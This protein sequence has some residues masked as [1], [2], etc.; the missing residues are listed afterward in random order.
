MPR[1]EY[2][3][4]PARELL[5]RILDLGKLPEFSSEQVT[6]ND[7]YLF[8]RDKVF[9]IA[10]MVLDRI[11]QTPAEFGSI[12]A[13]TSLNGQLQPVIA[14]L[15]Q[16]TGN[17]NGIHLLNAASYME[18]GVLQNLWGLPPNAANTVDTDGISILLEKQAGFSTEA[19]RQLGVRR[20]ELTNA[21]TAQSQRVEA[22]AVQIEASRELLARDRAESAA[23]VAN[24]Q[25]QYEL[26]E[27]I[28][29]EK[30]QEVIEAAMAALL[31]SRSD[32][33][34]AN[35]KHLKALEGYK[36][37]AARI[38]QVVGNI[39]ITG[40]Y[41]AIAKEEKKAADNWRL[42]TLLFFGIGVLIAVCTFF[43]YWGE[44]VSKEMLSGV[45]VRMLYALAIAAPAWYT[46]RES[47]RHRTNADRAKQTELELASLGPFIELM[48]PEKK[49]EIRELLAKS[50]F[51]RSVE[52]H[53]IESP[54]DSKALDDLLSK[55][56]DLAKIIRR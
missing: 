47:A 19:I 18:Q 8:A 48:P 15:A 9:A 11:R 31:K 46:A 17:Q 6:S 10:G 26:G 3:N 32:A 38:V 20:D 30:F 40:N 55:L 43:M 42:G 2:E 7:E 23:A 22:L 25:K 16:F 37:E 41:Q 49:V 45:A 28:R 12:P 39:G 33:D 50:Y 24:L 21:L 56:V 27:A 52:E 14:E 4:H 29:N 36:D 44:P 53:R 54:M 51:G 34:A 1:S 35:D 13:L 5:T